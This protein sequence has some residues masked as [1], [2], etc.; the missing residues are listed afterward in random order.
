MSTTGRAAVLVEPNRLET[1][2]VPVTDPEPG[3]VL[4]R[5]VIGGV[6]GSDKHILTGEAG[7]MPFPIILGHEGIGRIEKLGSGVFRDYASVEVSEGDLVYW[8]PSALC[9]HCYN[10]T[11]LDAPPCE[12]S[13]FFEHAE[14]PNWGSYADYAWLP[15]GMAFFRLPDHARPEAL[16]AL[17]CALPTALGGYEQVAPIQVGDTVVVQG[18]GPVGLSAVLIAA[19]AGAAEIIVI[20]RREQRREV[21]MALGATH[22]ISRAQFDEPQR[23]EMIYDIVGPHG[24]NIVVE[25][26]GALSAFPEG[27]ALT[28][29]YGRY[30]VLGLWGEI[31]TSTLS[32]RD[33]TTRNVTIGGATFAKHKHY[34]RAM[35]LAAQV[36]D[37]YPLADLITHRFAVTD[38]AEAL[39][40]IGTPDA[41]KAIIDP[42]L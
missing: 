6:C 34:Y 11:I 23:R 36:Q 12:N 9:G 37:R 19:V 22:T 1:W 7:I 24:P 38:A 16:A 25:A 20:D 31:G 39:E 42:T 15:R 4:V 35:K 33:L 17:G 29:E 21:A 5:V 18:A 3:G 8:A 30:V 14:R 13:E 32:P 41:I 10:C 2:E 27:V 26:A 28:G 40:T